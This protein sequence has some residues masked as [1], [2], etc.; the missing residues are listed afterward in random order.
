M[1]FWK[2]E[3][4]WGFGFFYEKSCLYYVYML[5]LAYKEIGRNNDGTTSLT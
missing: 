4:F 3:T 2:T 5:I 1:V